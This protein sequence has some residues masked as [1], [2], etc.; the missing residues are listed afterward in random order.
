MNISVHD[1]IEDCGF[2]DVHLV[3]STGEAENFRARATEDGGLRFI[4]CVNSARFLRELNALALKDR[5]LC[6]V[7]ADHFFID[8][9]R[10]ILV[11]AWVED[12]SLA[13]VLRRKSRRQALDV[14]RTAVRLFEALRIVHE[15]GLV[16][17]DI[18]PENI[19]LN[20]AGAS[21]GQLMVADFGSSASLT[22][23]KS[24]PWR[25]ASPSYEAPESVEGRAG[26][27]SDLYA[28]GVVL[29][30]LIVGRRP[31]S[32][33]PSEIYKQSRF[34]LPPLDAI[35]TVELRVLIAVLLA[36]DLSLRPKTAQEVIDYLEKGA[37]FHVPVRT[38]PAN[39]LIPN[40]RLHGFT[41]LRGQPLSLI[42]DERASLFCFFVPS[43]L[44]VIDCRGD[45]VFKSQ[46]QG[47]A[48]VWYRQFLWYW[49]GA[50]LYRFDGYSRK[51][52]RVAHLKFPPDAFAVGRD[53]V[54]WISSGTL[55]RGGFD[56]RIHDFHRIY[57]YLS[58]NQLAV[59]DDQVYIA[60]GVSGS[61]LI[62]F[63]K[64]MELDQKTELK[65]VILD[66]CRGR[67]NSVH[68]LIESFEKSRSLVFIVHF[69][70]GRQESAEISEGFSSAS[71][72]HDGCVVWS[73]SRRFEVLENLKG[74]IHR[75][76]L[77]ADSEQSNT[78]KH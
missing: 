37:Q 30:E 62:R 12:G 71:L 16:H 55:F 64:A 13:D 75:A 74:R 28:V 36:T 29:Y 78:T 63:T 21:D 50:D 41:R 39:R 60:S 9:E 24:R 48:P 65:G 56:G 58:R 31:F 46:Q 2:E 42:S 19:L 1:L 72:S 14:K 61:T 53:S 51:N 10:C 17:G 69:Q 27:A 54:F 22:E 73:G 6:S 23:L 32:G 3:R 68:V 77:S 59:V 7:P 4:K 49:I 67:D 26:P 8:S 43:Q 5:T 35:P 25:A 18:K 20:D 70:D 45:E 40:L 11:F 52:E 33:M 47:P 15:A 76:E 44:R 34:E 38:P 57:G 66:L